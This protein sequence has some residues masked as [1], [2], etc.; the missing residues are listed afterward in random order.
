MDD[1]ESVG[2]A[3]VSGQGAHVEDVFI[4]QMKRRRAVLNLSQGD[5]SER[6]AALGGHLYQQTIA[7]L[8]SGQRSLKLAEADVLA[9]ALGTTLQ[10]MLAPVR[11]KPARELSNDLRER[12]EEELAQIR[13]SLRHAEA[14]ER[15]TARRMEARAAAAR[16]SQVALALAQHEAQAS[17]ERVVVLSDRY[18]QLD[19][20]LAEWRDLE[21][22]TGRPHRPRK[23]GS[24]FVTVEGPKD[25][26]TSNPEPPAGD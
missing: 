23:R 21:E 12:L 6:V 22:K 4:A 15:D 24:G 11:P 3:E 25:G 13:E 14:Q 26:E 17:R 18:R 1:V 10:E 19:G 8:E 16:E 5:L 9:R 2:D 7:K 20:Q